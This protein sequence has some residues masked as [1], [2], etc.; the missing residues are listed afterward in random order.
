MSQFFTFILPHQGCIQH[1]YICLSEV[2]TVLVPV[3][4]FDCLSTWDFVCKYCNMFLIVSVKLMFNNFQAFTLFRIYSTFQFASVRFYSSYPIGIFWCL[5]WDFECKYCSMF[6]IVSVKHMF[7]NFH[8]VTLFRIYS[9]FLFASVEFLHFL[10]QW[11]NLM[12]QRYFKCNYCNMLR[13][14]TCSNFQT[15][16]LFR[17]YL[18]FPYLPQGGDTV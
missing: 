16:T 15:Y 3:G 13:W 1:F 4:Y 18:T 10:S 7:N 2:F 14:S 12:S 11:D 5:S 17:I 9:T 8:T 6:P